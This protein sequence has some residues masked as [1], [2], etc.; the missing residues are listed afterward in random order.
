MFLSP[1]MNGLMSIPDEKVTS[2]VVPIYN[3]YYNY[4]FDFSLDLQILTLRDTPTAMNW[5]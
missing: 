2:R 1:C 5:F 3:G 4:L